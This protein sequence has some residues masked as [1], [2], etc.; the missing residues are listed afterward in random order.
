VTIAIA[1]VVNEGVVLASDSATTLLGAPVG[2]KRDVINVYES[3]SK[4]F[5]LYKALP[6]GGY[7]FGAGN[8]NDASISTLAKDFRS[9][10]MAGKPIGP[11]RWQF[12]PKG[13]TIEEVAI[14]AR[15]FL[16]EDRYLPVYGTGTDKPELGFNVAGY[17]SGSDHAEVWAI[18]VDST[19]A[20]AAPTPV[21]KANETGLAWA[22]QPEAI[23]RLVIGIATGLPD[24]LAKIG[25]PAADVPAAIAV[26]KNDL[27][28]P[29]VPPAMPIQDVIELARF[30]VHATVMFTKFAPGPSTVGGPIE[31]ATITKHE[32][33]KWVQRKHYYDATLNPGQ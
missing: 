33:F 30:L 29:V 32:G 14:A 8:I 23:S 22:G 25:V 2:G 24:S 21:R 28:I 17:S 26:I 16:Y 7:T 10:L 13:Y 20:C 19:G 9:T 12:K 31:I 18:A 15:Q 27:E 11:T 4:V 1:A 6:I 3:A 5:N